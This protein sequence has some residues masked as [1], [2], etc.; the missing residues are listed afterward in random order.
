MP[1]NNVA[2]PDKNLMSHHWTKKV[3][4]PKQHVTSIGG[5]EVAL[6]TARYLVCQ[7]W[8]FSNKNIYFR[9]VIGRFIKK[10]DIFTYLLLLSKVE[11]F[12]VPE[13]FLG[14]LGPGA[15]KQDC[16]VKG[17]M[18]GHPTHETKEFQNASWD[19]SL[20][21]LIGTSCS[22]AST[23]TLHRTVF[24]PSPTKWVSGYAHFLACCPP[25]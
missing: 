17:K 8:F 4:Y 2:P 12:S 10:Q 20:I 15:S 11:Y 25:S 13:R 14:T 21:A 24:P 9:K 5:W 1:S 16:P 6:S 7:S 22:E 3:H 18:Y 19:R 23:P